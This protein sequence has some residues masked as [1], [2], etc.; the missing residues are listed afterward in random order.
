MPF[1]LYEFL[2]IFYLDH[3]DVKSTAFLICMENTFWNISG[4]SVG[5]ANFVEL[6]KKSFKLYVESGTRMK[7]EAAITGS[8]LRNEQLEAGHLVIDS[9][10][11]NFKA[12]FY[13]L[14]TEHLLRKFTFSLYL[15]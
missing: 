11:E 1:C 8:L 13:R 10:S 2:I 15:P 14:I 12:N 5:D 9:D 4:E 3:D 6:F 7:A